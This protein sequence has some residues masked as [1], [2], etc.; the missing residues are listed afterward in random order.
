MR[1]ITRLILVLIIFS[2]GCSSDGLK[3]SVYGTLQ[4]MEGGRCHPATTAKPC[5]QVGYDEYQQQRKELE[6]NP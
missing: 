6:Q 2:T 5:T 1:N 4:N 3:R